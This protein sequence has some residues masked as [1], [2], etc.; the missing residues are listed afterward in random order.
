MGEISSVIPRPT[1]PRLRPWRKPYARGATTSFWTATAE[2]ALPR[3]TSGLPF[4]K[5]RLCDAVVFLNSSA[6]LGS[7]WCHTERPSPGTWQAELL[8]GPPAGAEAPPRRPVGARDQVW[9]F[10]RREHQDP[11]SA[12]RHDGLAD[13]S[14]ARW[15]ERRL[16]LPG[17]GGL[18]RRRC[19]RL[20]RVRP[21]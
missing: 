13:R 7:Q 16:P 3:G 2:T 5:L 8:G 1:R 12:L 19:R 21:T 10:A 4:H 15:D 6:S 9:D 18:G 20:F 17:A 11:L 14:L